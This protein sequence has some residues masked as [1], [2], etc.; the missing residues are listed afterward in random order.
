M[1]N[2][3][4]GL[5]L[6]SVLLQNYS[7]VL[8]EVLFTLKTRYTL[9]L[10]LLDPIHLLP[11]FVLLAGILG[12]LPLFVKLR[13]ILIDAPIKGLIGY[14]LLRLELKEQYWAEIFD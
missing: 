2:V 3:N 7:F 9:L 4:N 5:D 14:V 13:E 6:I 8:R 1:N 12:L 11:D 10:I